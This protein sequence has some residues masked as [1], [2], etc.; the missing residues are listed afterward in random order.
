[1]IFRKKTE[2]NER[3]MHE[4]N[5]TPLIDVSLVLVVMLLLATPLAFESSIAVRNSQASAKT[6]EKRDKNERIELKIVSDTHVR[7][8]RNVVARDELLEM[9]RPLLA[10]SSNRQV[11]IRC[12]DDVSHWVFVD[13][14]DKA[15]FCGARDIGFAGR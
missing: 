10:K 8:N 3:G 15:K 2:N 4:V 5:M 11:V 9:L 1:M 7:V 14:L 12:A 13:V 6:A